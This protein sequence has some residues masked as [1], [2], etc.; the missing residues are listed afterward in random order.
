[1]GVLSTKVIAGVVAGTVTLGAVG[2]AF[3]GGETVDN[4]KSQLIDMKNKIVSYEASEIGL[5]DKIGFIKADATDKLTEANGKIV[6]AK[7]KIKDLEAEKTLLQTQINHLNDEVT[8]LKADLDMA[9]AT[10][11]T[12][13]AE[14]ARLQEELNGVNADL[15]TLQ[16]EYDALLADYNALVEENDDLKAEANRANAEVQEANDKVAELQETSTQVTTVIEG[17]SPLTESELN[18]IGTV[19]SPEVHDAELVVQNLN[20]T[21]IQDGQSET[22]K[23]AH[24]DL[25]IQEGDRVWRVTNNNK[26]KVYVEWQFAGGGTTGELVAN[27]SQTFYMTGNGG[28]MIIKWQDEN[29]VWKSITKAG[30]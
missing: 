25:D 1:M 3:T 29:G 7:T 20:L 23:A 9:N 21:Y 27:P 8:G 22:F 2:V 11:I 28:T 26:F 12:K 14:I 4:V 5:L 13:E 6:D 10:I 24:P 19:N 16:A 18:A 15:D 30:A 17:M